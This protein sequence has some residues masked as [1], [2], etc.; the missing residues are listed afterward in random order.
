MDP[1]ALVGVNL[2][3][4]SACTKLVHGLHVVDHKGLVEKMK[5]LPF[6]LNID[7]STVKRSKKRV[8][9]ILVCYYDEDEQKSMTSLYGSIEMFTV[10]A[11]TVYDVVTQAI[12]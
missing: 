4:K 3:R 6:S 7:E 11:Q 2:C 8:L 12:H 10:N 5:K 1:K 9:N